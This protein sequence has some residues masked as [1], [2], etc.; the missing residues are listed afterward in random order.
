[1]PTIPT[2]T[3][4]SSI[5]S[6]PSSVVSDIKLSPRSTMASA[7]LPAANQVQAYAIKK[8]DNEEKLQAKKTLLDLKAESDK[9]VE[10]Q[11]NNP[12]E[13]ESINVW[14]TNFQNLS[15]NKIA[16]IQNKRIKKLVED[17][18]SLEESESIYHLKTNSFKAY[19]KESIQ[20][21]N[22]KINM[23]VAKYKGTDN[24]ILKVK[25]KEE[26][27][28]DATDFNNEHEL[29]SSDLENRLKTIDASLLFV[30]SDYTIGLGFNNAA[31][32]IAKLDSSIDGASFI[33]DEIFSN[34]IFASYNQKINDLTVKGDPNADYD[35]AERLLSQLESFERYT[36]SKVVSGDREVKFANLRQR[37]LT[38]KVSHDSLV[39]KIRMGEQF[40]EYNKN[41]RSI[42]NSEF[43]NALDARFNKSANKEKAEEATF[44]YDQRIEL[45]LS[46]NPDASLFETQ[47]YSR[48]LRLN[49]IDKY[50]ETSIETITAFNL[51]ENKFNV[52]REARDVNR[53]YTEYKTDPSAKN[54][55]KTLAKLNGY[56]D[57]SGKPDVEMFMNDYTKILKQR[58]EG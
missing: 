29:G 7:L 4:K 8:R 14:K 1:M 17:S 12:N 21:Y 5:T 37:L 16:N 40:E 22:D 18:L 44:E 41:Q 57:E 33:N 43:F 9:I 6:E 55:L 24:A 27:Y 34:N 38:E 10:S 39:M 20:V 36:G 48:D 52:I 19:E 46:S 32:T 42:L 25:Y 13:E 58:Q 2:F 56:V 30:D 31:E 3:A 35:E 49:L 11:K 26:L 50:Q 15:K 47:Q 53:S 54:I 23:D 51:E 45:Y 28:R